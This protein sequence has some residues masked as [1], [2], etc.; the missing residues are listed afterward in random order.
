MGLCSG[1]PIRISD[2][3]EGADYWETSYDAGS[4]S[5]ARKSGLVAKYDPVASSFKIFPDTSKLLISSSSF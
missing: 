2:N 5:F 3:G 1:G 4:L